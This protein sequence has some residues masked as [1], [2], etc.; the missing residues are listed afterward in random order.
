L[1]PFTCLRGSFRTNI[2]RRGYRLFRT[3]TCRAV[4]EVSG[5]KFFVEDIG[6]S[7]HV[8]VL[9]DVS[10][11]T[12]F[13]ADIGCSGYAHGIGEVSGP[14]FFVAD[15]GCSEYVHAVL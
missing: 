3:C 1:T 12:I 13:V 14:P 7:G 15:I 9:G 10:G 11:L 6:C 2:F 5:R 8:H 4:E